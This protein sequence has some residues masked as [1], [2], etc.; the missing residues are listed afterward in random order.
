M[1]VST[2]ATPE[3]HT[4]FKSESISI[5]L[6]T[7]KKTRK[8]E[9]NKHVDVQKGLKHHANTITVKSKSIIWFY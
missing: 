9:T 1:E 3:Y 8:Q 7:I 6:V 4:N 2:A 5:R